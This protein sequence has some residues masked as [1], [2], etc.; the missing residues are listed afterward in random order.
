MF[1]MVLRDDVDIPNDY[2]CVIRRLEPTRPVFV[3]QGLHEI[4]RVV[5]GGKD[6]PNVAIG[7]DTPLDRICRAERSWVVGLDH[8][9]AATE[10]VRIVSHTH[11]PAG[12]WMVRAP[13]NK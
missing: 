13:E 12:D 8:V 10:T 9:A 2:N 5:V 7:E 3:E 6:I 11:P 1:L 4:I